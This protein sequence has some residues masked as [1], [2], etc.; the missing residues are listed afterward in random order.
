[1]NVEQYESLRS[2][3]L[4]ADPLAE[5]VKDSPTQTKVAGGEL[6]C[7]QIGPGKQAEQPGGRETD[8]RLTMVLA[9]LVVSA[10]KE[11]ADG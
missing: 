4:S 2:Q 6:E 5:C 3:A 8:E 10:E 7:R 9:D 1:M 11:E